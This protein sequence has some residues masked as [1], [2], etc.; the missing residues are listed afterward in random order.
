[1]IFISE[2]SYGFIF[3]N[4]FNGWH[5]LHLRIDEYFYDVDLLKLRFSQKDTD[6]GI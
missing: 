5:K 1:M 2:K 6:N 3:R 4:K